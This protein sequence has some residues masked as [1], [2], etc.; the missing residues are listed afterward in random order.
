MIQWL[1]RYIFRGIGILFAVGMITILV[2]A[3]CSQIRRPDN[4]TAA[5]ASDIRGR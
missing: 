3:I 2:L 1:Y 4:K 5:P